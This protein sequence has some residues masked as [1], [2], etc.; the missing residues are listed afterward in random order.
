MDLTLL[1]STRHARKQGGWLRQ[2]TR[3]V[4][5]R[6][7]ARQQTRCAPHGPPGL[8]TLQATARQLG[9]LPALFG[10]SYLAPNLRQSALKHPAA[11]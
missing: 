11:G 3:V 8:A 1:A 6:D 2:R 7:A 10:Q 9:R 4:H 5:K